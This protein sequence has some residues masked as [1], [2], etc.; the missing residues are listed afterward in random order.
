[1]ASLSAEAEDA[2]GALALTVALSAIFYGAIELL[3]GI[4]WLGIL[5]VAAILIL[6]GSFAG[7][8]LMRWLFGKPHSLCR[9]S[10][11]IVVLL[12]TLIGGMAVAILLSFTTELKDLPVLLI[13]FVAMIAIGALRQRL[14]MEV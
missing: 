13:V 7:D 4:G 14:G 5:L 12:L 10:V 11:M 1:M 9:D 8:F 6:G 2:L 3:F